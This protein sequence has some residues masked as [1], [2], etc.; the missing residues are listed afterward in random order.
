MAADDSAEIFARAAKL[1]GRLDVI[2]SEPGVR[3]PGFPTKPMSC[4]DPCLHDV[5]A[6]SGKGVF[7]N[8][9]TVCRFRNQFTIETL[10]SHFGLDD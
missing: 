7:A 4:G 2:E 10:A 8:Q 9:N 1:D 3:E 5:V 6:C